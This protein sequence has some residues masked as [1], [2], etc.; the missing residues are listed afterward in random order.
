M[1][2]PS[3]SSTLELILRFLLSEAS[4]PKGILSVQSKKHGEASKSLKE[5]LKAKVGHVKHSVF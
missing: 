4:L 1:L 3:S 2:S 5:A